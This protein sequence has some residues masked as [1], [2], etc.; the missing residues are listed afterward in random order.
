MMEPVVPPLPSNADPACRIEVFVQRGFD[1]VELTGITSTVNTA[2][3]IVGT[4]RFTCRIVSDMPGLMKGDAQ[5]LVRAEPA[6]E[7]YGFGDVM[8]VLGGRHIER[9]GWIRRVRAMQR[10]NRPV[11]LLSDAATAF[12]RA[13][14]SRRGH[15][16]THWRDTA[17]LREQGYYPNLT[18]R[19]AEQSEGVTTAAGGGATVE[20]VIGLISTFLGPVEVAELGNRLLL[21]SI[22]HSDAEQPHDIA[23]NAGLFDARVTQAIK[24]ME[25][26]MEDPLSMTELTS[27]VGLSTRHVER[28]FREVFDETPARFYK[29][30]RVRRARTMIENTL[31]PLIDVAIATGFCSHNALSRAVRDEYGATPSKMRARKSIKLINHQS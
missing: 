30:L 15:V 26:N 19:L 29:R 27:R 17:L 5:V 23:D 24:L 20:L 7:G 6:I 11:V 31:I 22:R 28:V 4:E 16:T 9:S 2:N 8:I 18:T 21:S 25:T 13:A 10:Q 14:D 1:A 3:S 12:I